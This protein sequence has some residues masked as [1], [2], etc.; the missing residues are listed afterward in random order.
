MAHE[1]TTRRRVEFAET[2]MAGIA[3]F[4]C[5]F[6]WMET[7]EHDFV[8]SLGQRVHGSS[9]GLDF[10]FARTHASCDY[11]RPVTYLDLV[12]IRLR[13]TKKSRKSFGYA[14]T[15]L[16][17]PESGEPEPVASGKL[18]VVCVT[19]PPGEERMRATDMPVELLEAV[20]IAP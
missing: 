10:G 14:F 6:R 9:A 19:R 8:R 2:D 7:A 3:H 4:S 17:V 5:F 11:R 20:D 1:F 12:E 18:E 13:V 15:F 16:L